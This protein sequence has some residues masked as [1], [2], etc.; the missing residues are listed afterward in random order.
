M[1]NLL[2]KRRYVI[3]LSTKGDAGSLKS[4]Y[5]YSIQ[6]LITFSCWMPFAVGSLWLLIAFSCLMPFDDG[7][8]LAP[9]SLYLLIDFSCWMPLADVRN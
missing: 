2:N 6:L 8:P 5:A 9:Y 7:R 3:N 4:L 1:S